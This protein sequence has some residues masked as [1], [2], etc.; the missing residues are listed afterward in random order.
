MADTED[1]S[2]E[3]TP[4]AHAA[5]HEDAGTDEISIAGLAG[6]PLELAAHALLPT[7]HQDAPDLILTH[8]GD[9]AAHH[10]A[11]TPA[12]ARAAINNIFGADGKADADIDLDGHDLIGG[13][14]L[15]PNGAFIGIGPA[16][17]RLE[18]YTAGYA[19]FMGCNVGVGTITPPA[20]LTLETGDGLIKAGSGVFSNKAATTDSGIEFSGDD[21][22]KSGVFTEAHGQAL[23]YAINAP[24]I[25]DRDESALGAIF[26]F[27][28]RAAYDEFV[29]TAY[30]LGTSALT[31]RFRLVLSSGHIFQNEKGGATYLGGVGHMFLFIRPQAGRYGEILFQD[32]VTTRFQ[33]GKDAAN[34]L[35]I[36][37]NILG[38]THT[39]LNMN[40]GDL[41]ILRHNA[42]TV[43]LKLGGT[44]VTASAAEINFLHD[45]SY[46]DDDSGGAGFKLLRVPN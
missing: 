31:D 32:G 22:L 26:S 36:Y 24:Q 9:A 28:T 41:D 46:G 1:Y 17:E 30:L 23:S 8:K 43:G 2:E 11:F 7:V 16:L 18:F 14:V 44:L 38:G 4:T 42:S 33:F 12:L 37:S 29:I 19:A 5:S 25:G 6:E 15:L 27:D 35:R 20:Q 34:N 13:D 21:R 45:V 10:T 40:T 3:A 39:Y